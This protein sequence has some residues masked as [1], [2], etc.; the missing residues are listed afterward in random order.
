[1]VSFDVAS[2]R[3]ILE[4]HHCGRVVPQGSYDELCSEIAS[5]AESPSRRAELGAA[6][7]CLA[8]RLFSAES[9]LNK[10]RSLI[11]TLSDK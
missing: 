9:C 7:A 10:Y 8:P 1:V 6:G 11:L 5:L 2:A 3:E 4:E